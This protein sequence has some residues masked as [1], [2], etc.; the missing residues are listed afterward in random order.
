[1]QDCGTLDSTGAAFFIGRAMESCWSDAVQF[2][3]EAR[4]K[5]KKFLAALLALGILVAGD[6]AVGQNFISVG[7]PRDG[8]I[9]H[10]ACGASYL[11]TGEVEQ[12]QSFQYVPAMLTVRVKSILGTNPRPMFVSAH[13]KNP[14]LPFE[15]DLKVGDEI[16]IEPTVYMSQIP[17]VGSPTLEINDNLI[18]HTQHETLSLSPRFDD[19]DLAPLLKALEGKTYII[20]TTSPGEMWELSEGPSIYKAMV[21]HRLFALVDAADYSNCVKPVGVRAYLTLIS[22][23][24][25]GCAVVVV[26]FFWWLL[27]KR[28]QKA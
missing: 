3:R 25:I 1:V 15:T 23:A 19:P 12:I 28:R 27:R 2:W 5:T 4:M 18:M 10:A 21:L 6:G 13:P 26:S 16:V 7:T 8:K 17:P 24:I 11:V 22:P 9:H 14:M 20:S